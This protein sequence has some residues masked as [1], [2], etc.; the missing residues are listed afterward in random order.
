MRK[1][2]VLLALLIAVITATPSLAY[3]YNRHNPNHHSRTAA[4]SAQH[5]HHSKS[6]AHAHDE[7]GA[8]WNY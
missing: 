6:M 1:P 3:D 7:G 2:T 8:T 4:P 5:N